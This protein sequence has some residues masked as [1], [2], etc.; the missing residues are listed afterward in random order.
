MMF[1]PPVADTALDRLESDPDGK[2][3]AALQRLQARHSD[4]LLFYLMKAIDLATSRQC[5]MAET[6]Q[7]SKD[8]RRHAQAARDL[9]AFAR[10][11][12]LIQLWT[13]LPR[14]AEELDAEADRHA[15]APHHLHINRKIGGDYAEQLLALRHFFCSLRDELGLNCRDRKIRQAAVWLVEA[16]LACEI[17]AT[18]VSQAL[19]DSRL[20]SPKHRFESLKRAIPLKVQSHF[21]GP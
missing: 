3:A 1:F 21:R 13:L 16:A 8:C 6:E 5:I 14:L 20:S 19:R 4:M 7:L 15:A 17:P 11:R 9:Y 12:V 10:D 2:V 18:R